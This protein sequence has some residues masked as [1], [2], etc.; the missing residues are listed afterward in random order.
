MDQDPHKIPHSS[1]PAGKQQSP[2]AGGYSGSTCTGGLCA[3]AWCAATRAQTG[4]SSVTSWAQLVPRNLR[5]M[6]PCVPGNEF[7]CC[8]CMLKITWQKDLPW[9]AAVGCTMA[10]RGAGIAD[11][12]VHT[13]LSV[14]LHL[15]KPLS[16]QLI[17]VWHYS[18]LPDLSSFCEIFVSWHLVSAWRPL[19]YLTV[20]AW[21][22]A[23]QVLALSKRTQNSHHLLADLP[24]P[25][26]SAS[27]NPCKVW[28]NTPGH[29]LFVLGVTAAA[30]PLSFVVHSP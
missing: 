16:D 1:S 9:R 8:A 19:L 21:P 26:Q 29:I 6:H 4:V 11:S 23:C 10:D 22:A 3:G 7:I 24:A 17:P 28:A 12:L 20:P 14:H 13:A 5:K 2:R 30:G 25:E 27:E 15:L 18:G